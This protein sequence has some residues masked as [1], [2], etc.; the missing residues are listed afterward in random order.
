MLLNKPRVIDVF[1]G[2][3]G[4]SLG[5]ELAGWQVDTALE[6]NEIAVSTHKNNLSGVSHICDDVRNVNFK[7]FKGVDLVAGGPPCQPFSVSGKQ[8]G[9]DDARD[10]IPE[11]I[12][13]VKESKPKAFLMENVAGLTTQKFMTYLQLQIDEFLKL[14]YRVKWAVLNAADY[15]VPQRRLRLFIVGTTKDYDFSFPEPTHGVGRLPYITVKEA[16]K[17]L[18]MDSPNLAKVV[19]AKNP[20]IRK[21]PYA[22]M[23]L[24]GKGRPLDMNGV[25]HTIPATAGG[26]RTHVLDT[27]GVLKKYHEHLLRGGK[28]RVGEVEGCKRLTVG[29][30]AALQTFPSWFKFMGTKSQQYA[31]IGNAVPPTLAA[32]VAS[33]LLESISF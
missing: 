31:Q 24:N 21:S 20:I 27:K 6:F 11:F 7:R 32:A 1:S 14:K 12:R 30:S 4:L 13:A 28:P 22:G 17:E 16:I 9:S 15:G 10:M 25:S 26:N 5:L 2:A 23:L 3:G 18:V 33:K 8:L 29:Q 19:Y